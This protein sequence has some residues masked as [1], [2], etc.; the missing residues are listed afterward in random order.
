MITTIEKLAERTRKAE[1]LVAALGDEVIRLK[2]VEL[3]LIARIEGLTKGGQYRHFKGGIYRLVC[4][5]KDS[6]TKAEFMVYEGTTGIWVRSRASFEEVI[7]RD[8]VCTDDPCDYG[9]P[10]HMVESTFPR[11]ES[12]DRPK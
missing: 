4:V 5:A 1:K 6:E 10:G 2:D 12:L 7:T 3:Q 8:V 9:S 11:F